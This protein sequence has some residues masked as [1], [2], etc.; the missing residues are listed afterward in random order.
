MA[1]PWPTSFAPVLAVA[2]ELLPKL[3]CTL[4][5]VF[6]CEKLVTNQQILVACASAHPQSAKLHYH[7]CRQGKLLSALSQRIGLFGC[8]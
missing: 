2:P 4:G 7:A 5:G 1:S 3:N 8:Q 6:G